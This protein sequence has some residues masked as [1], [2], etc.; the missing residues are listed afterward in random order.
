MGRKQEIR[1]LADELST[2]DY[3]DNFT[4]I[5]DRAEYLI[6]EG[7]RKQDVV[8]KELLTEIFNYLDE[9]ERDAENSAKEK[10]VL[11]DIVLQS[12]IASVNLALRSKYS[13]E[14]VE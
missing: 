5:E 8:R 1:E 13:K 11:T 9:L 7:W 4:Y 14:G 3:R 6:D 2:M 10:R 12:A